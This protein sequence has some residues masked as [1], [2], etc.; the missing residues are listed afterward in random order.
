M[1]L[2]TAQRRAAT[3]AAVAAAFFASEL[4]VAAAPETID[5]ECRA[6]A[7][8]DLIEMESPESPL[9]LTIAPSQGGELVSIRLARRGGKEELLYR[10]GNFCPANGFEGKA[11]ILWPAT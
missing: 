8:R 6:R 5:A 3:T 7:P 11:P 4:L 9:R 1:R 2:P 10:G